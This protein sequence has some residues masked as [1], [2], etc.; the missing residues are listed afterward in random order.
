MATPQSRLTKLTKNLKT[1]RNKEEFAKD[2]EWARKI[3]VEY[4]KKTDPEWCLAGCLKVLDV[5][6]KENPAPGKIHFFPI[7]QFFFFLSNFQFCR[8]NFIIFSEYLLFN[9]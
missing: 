6:A 1:P 8:T 7:F 3:V 5:V 9:F 4:I 2:R